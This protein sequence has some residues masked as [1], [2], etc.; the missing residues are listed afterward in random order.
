MRECFEIC[1]FAVAQDPPVVIGSAPRQGTKLNTELYKAYTSSGL[2]VEF[3]VWPPLL[4]HEGGPVLCK[5]VAQGYNEQTLPTTAPGH[6]MSAWEE[7]ETSERVNS[8]TKTRLLSSHD[9]RSD[10]YRN[11]SNSHLDIRSEDGYKNRYS[12]SSGRPLIEEFNYS[13]KVIRPKYSDSSILAQSYRTEN[14]PRSARRY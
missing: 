10:V 4:L 8:L 6:R 9:T 5:G 12:S 14:R 7:K 1:W 13:S 2:L 3:V 11:T